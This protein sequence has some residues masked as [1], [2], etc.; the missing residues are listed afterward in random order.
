MGKELDLDVVGAT[1]DVLETWKEFLEN[2]D[3]P[4]EDVVAVT[5]LISYWTAKL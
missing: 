1:V 4:S 2:N 3:G 5:G